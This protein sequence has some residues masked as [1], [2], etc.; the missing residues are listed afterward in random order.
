MSITRHASWL[1]FAMPGAGMLILSGCLR[2]NPGF[3]ISTSAANATI[4]TLVS[5]FLT[6]LLGL[7][8]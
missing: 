7:G 2:P 4:S 3:F 8:G 6:E 1:R 5:A